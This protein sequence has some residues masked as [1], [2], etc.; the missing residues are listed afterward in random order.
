MSFY[1]TQ[2]LVENMFL[3]APSSFS[4]RLLDK[5]LSIK[6]SFIVEIAKL[7][8]EMKPV[9]MYLSRPWPSVVWPLRKIISIVTV[10]SFRKVMHNVL[11]TF[12][13]PALTRN[14]PSTQNSIRNAGLVL[15]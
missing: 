14:S 5:P 11:P 9:P 13:F 4:S 10:M 1:V 2:T 3:E 6:A 15:F 12:T 8:S 7:I